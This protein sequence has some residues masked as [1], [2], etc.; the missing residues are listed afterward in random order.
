MAGDITKTARSKMPQK[1][2]LPSPRLPD[3]KEAFIA[4]N[5]YNMRKNIKGCVQGSCRPILWNIQYDT[6][7]KLKFTD[8]TRVVAFADDLI[9]MI[10]ADSISEAENIANIE[11]GKVVMWAKNKTKF[12]EE[13]SKV[14]LMTRR[15]RKERKRN[16]SIHKQ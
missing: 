1:P 7:L 8:H 4:I 3:G 5:S 2:L 13:K 9:L 11:I 6:V 15:K 16:I 14:M 12:K 10:R